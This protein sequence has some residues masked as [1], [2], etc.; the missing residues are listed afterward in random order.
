M[1]FFMSTF[2]EVYKIYPNVVKYLDHGF[3]VLTDSMGN[4]SSI[5]ESA[6]VS[7]GGDRK[8]RTVQEDT[9]LIRYMM[10]HRHTSPFEMVELK[11]LLK[12]PIFVMRQHIR[13]RTASVNE[14]SGRYSVMS[15]EFY[16][17]ELNRLQGQST[18]N[19]QMSSGQLDWKTANG[20]DTF[21]RDCYAMSYDGYKACLDMG[22][23][24]ELARIQLPV[25]NYTEL[26]WKIDLHNFL[27][28]A[29]LRDDPGHAQDEI[30]QLAQIMYGMVKKVVPIACQAY[31]DYRKNAVTFSALEL[32]SLVELFDEEFYKEGAIDEFLMEY[33]CRLRGREV[34]EF[35]HKLQSIIRGRS[36]D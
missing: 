12:I 28:Y 6:R 34:A 23:S 18:D 17:P 21:L 20:I 5:A 4:D 2:E 13:H 14:Y 3:V 26:Y 33:P 24:R 25:A 35:K 30:V 31:E 1:R 11:F 8:T 27:H 16:L 29:G 9:N 10:R 22:L 32:E 7:Y 15:D 36:N 19:K